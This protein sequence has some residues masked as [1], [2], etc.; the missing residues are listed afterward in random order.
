MN[1]DE[2]T[3][4]V[5]TLR[6]KGYSLEKIA[7]TFIEKGIKTPKGKDIWTRMQVKRLLNGDMTYYR[8]LPELRKYAKIKLEKKA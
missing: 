8:A 4:Q 6:A 2:L 5:E 3:N 7:K 1:V